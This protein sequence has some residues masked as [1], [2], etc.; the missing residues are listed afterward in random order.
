[1]GVDSDEISKKIIEREL[2]K[3][4]SGKVN[5]DAESLANLIGTLKS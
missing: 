3:D 5:T 4:S 1:M 2:V